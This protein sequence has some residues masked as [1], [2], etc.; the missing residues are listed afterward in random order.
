MQEGTQNILGLVASEDAPC[1]LSSGKYEIKSRGGD[2]HIWLVRGAKSVDEGV[3]RIPETI[4][5]EFKGFKP[6]RSTAMALQEGGSGAR[7]LGSGVEADDNDPGTADVIVFQRAPRIFVGCTH[8]ETMR[9]SA[10]E[11]MTKLEQSAITP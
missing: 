8:G 4:A 9:T 7:V 11:I 5:S 1:Q 10:Q 6:N 3:P 2:V